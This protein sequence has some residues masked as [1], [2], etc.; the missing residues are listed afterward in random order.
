MVWDNP[1][2]HLWGW[3]SCL[4]KLIFSWQR[5][6]KYRQVGSLTVDK[7]EVVYFYFWIFYCKTTFGCKIK[8]ERCISSFC[9]DP[10]QI[11]AHR[12]HTS[13]EKTVTL[14]LLG[15][16]IRQDNLILYQVEARR[17]STAAISKTTLTRILLN[18][19]METLA[20]SASL[21]LGTLALPS[22]GSF[23]VIYFKPGWTSLQ[24]IVRC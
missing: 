11:Q 17:Q 2:K 24:N 8:E 10:V 13:I 4:H 12:G 22:Q 16:T 14:Q 15:N 21:Y 19:P 20:G 23:L 6:A 18:T 3:G 5:L 9:R 1:C 7:P